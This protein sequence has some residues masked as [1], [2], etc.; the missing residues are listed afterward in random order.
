MKILIIDD[1][2]SAIN[3]LTSK[4][5]NYPD[6]Q[7]VGMAHNAAEGFELLN[8]IQADVL[9]L[10]VEMPDMSGMEFLSRM[11]EYGIGPH[12]VVI[13]TAYDSYVL[14]ALRNKAFDFLL[15]PI[16][17]DDMD[18]V[19][20]RLGEELTAGHAATA[21]D[22]SD[23]IK[24]KNDKLLL[25]INAVDFRLV[26]IHDI[27][28]FQY[29]HDLRVW[30]VITAG[31]QTPIRLKRCANKDILMCLGDDFVQVSQKYIVNIQYLMEVRDNVCVFYPPFENVDYVKV[32][33]MYRRKLV[34]RFNTI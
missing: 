26:E 34:N 29:N 16:S 18:G 19:M 28:A 21:G 23:V 10:D 1:A 7:V 6:T 3:A 25:Y 15:K 8:T 33:R 32:G 24:K 30:E 12:L 4:L 2:L 22:T 17:D 11:R 5:A 14:S 31:T 13:Y 27:C 9:F 20:R